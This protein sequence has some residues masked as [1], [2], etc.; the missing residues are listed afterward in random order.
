MLGIIS[1]LLAQTSA[2]PPCPPGQP[3][4]NCASPLSNLT[5]TFGRIISILIPVGG[6]VLF[7]M[8]II[9]GFY[10]ITSNGD[11]RKVE[12]AKATITYAIGGIVLL[13][14]AFFIIQVIAFFAGVP[15]IL[16]FNI[17]SN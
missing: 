8:L 6:I 3:V 5:D 11:P 17:Y 14:L 7:V 9:G 10:F 16:N 13:A 15:T 2:T 4:G 1:M 12:G